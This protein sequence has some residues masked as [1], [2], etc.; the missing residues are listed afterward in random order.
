[1]KVP[2]LV[3]LTKS[4]RYLFFLEVKVTIKIIVLKFWMIAFYLIP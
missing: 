3:L 1:M 4:S 2:L